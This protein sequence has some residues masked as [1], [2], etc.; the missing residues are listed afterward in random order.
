MHS[1]RRETSFEKAGLHT[2]TTEHPNDEAEQSSSTNSSEL[3]DDTE[4]NS[5][6]R[7]FEA[8]LP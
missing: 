3:A 6:G 7:A 8:L 2:E 5:A 4:T 1:R